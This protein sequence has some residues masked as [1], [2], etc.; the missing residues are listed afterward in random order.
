LEEK[1]K[2]EHCKLEIQSDSEYCP[3]CGTVLIENTFCENHLEA[4]AKGVCVICTIPFCNN[5]GHNDK[6]VF[7]CIT[8]K[9][10]EIYEGMAKVFGTLDEIQAK[11]VE[12]FL[13]ESGI[14]P[15]IY[16]RKS[17]PM[18]LGGTDYSLFQ[19]SGD[20]NGHLLNEIKLMVPCSEV[21][22]AEKMISEFNI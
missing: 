16:S 20:F 7:L 8:H 10:Y 18:H 15:F 17:S 5:C 4:K 9:G 2:C 12:S 19:A 1:S 11:H 14:H 21:L 3:R 13:K 6:N 22:D